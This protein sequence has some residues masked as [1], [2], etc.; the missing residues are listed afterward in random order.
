MCVSLSLSLPIYVCLM[1]RATRTVSTNDLRFDFDYF[2]RNFSVWQVA[3]GNGWLHGHGHGHAGSSFS[4]W[5]PGLI[6]PHTTHS[7]IKMVYVSE[8]T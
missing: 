7:L 6:Q 3:N 1:C 5:I 4:I 2:C 8:S